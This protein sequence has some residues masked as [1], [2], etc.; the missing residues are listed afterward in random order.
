MLKCVSVVEFKTKWYNKLYET[1]KRVEINRLKN[2]PEHA[3]QNN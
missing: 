1:C 3:D 2:W